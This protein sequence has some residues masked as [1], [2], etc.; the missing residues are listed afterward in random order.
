[1]FALPEGA[2]A[3]VDGYWAFK[4]ERQE[5]VREAQSRAREFGTRYYW[6]TGADVALLGLSGSFTREDVA[7]A[8]KAKAKTAHPDAGGDAEAFQ[9]LVNARDQALAIA[10]E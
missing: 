5:I 3:N 10:A 6:R 9:R 4:Q 7:R 1:V 8:F 2:Q